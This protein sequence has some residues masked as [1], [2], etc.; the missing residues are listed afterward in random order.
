MKW[1]IFWDSSLEPEW[2]N[3]TSGYLSRFLWW[4]WFDWGED[5]TASKTGGCVH[6]VTLVFRMAQK[7]RSFLLSEVNS[8]PCCDHWLWASFS[9]LDMKHQSVVTW[10]IL[11]FSWHAWEFTGFCHT[12]PS[13]PEN[14]GMW[15]LPYSENKPSVQSPLINT[16]LAPNAKDRKSVV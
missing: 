16:H 12:I 5:G 3:I 13:S 6:W 11:V 9:F 1:G 7:P 10:K 4:V 2:K 8:A 14:D 15:Q